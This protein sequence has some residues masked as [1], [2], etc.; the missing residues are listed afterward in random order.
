VFGNTNFFLFQKYLAGGAPKGEM[1]DE[2]YCDALE[3]RIAK[4]LCTI[5]ALYCVGSMWE[6]DVDR[7]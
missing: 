2:A 1:S 6:T 7:G 3:T 5:E 4:V